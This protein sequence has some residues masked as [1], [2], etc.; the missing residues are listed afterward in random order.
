MDFHLDHLL[1][2][3]DVTVSSC[4]QQEGFIFLQLDFI[5]DG[6]LCPHCQTYTDNL[7]Q[8]RP[9]L[10]RDLSIFGQG[11]YLKVPRRQF[12]CSQCGKYPTEP[13][14]FVNKRSNYTKRYQEYIY[15]KVKELT[16]EQVSKNEQLSPEKV[17]NIFQKMTKLKKKDWGNPERLGLDEFSRQKGQGN[18]VTVVSNLDEGSLLEVINS[19]KSEEIIEALKQQPASIR[20]NIQ[21]VCVDMW[22]GFKKVIT[23]VFPNALVVI[24]RF[25]VIK[26][27]NKALNKLRLNL[28]LKG[29]KNRCLLLKNNQDLTE[30]EQRELRELLRISPCLSIAYELKEELRDIY[31][32]TTTVKKGLRSL[33]KWLISARV[34]FGKTADP[35]ESHLQDICHYFIQRT[36]NGT[37]E[38]LNNKIKLIL[39]QSYGFSNFDSMR[40]KLLACLF[41]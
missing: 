19:H 6:I 5:N 39:R 4:Q 37:M 12:I 28:D 24:D 32:E 16:I 33:K 1:N 26:L 31:E 35:L 2:L 38:G 25:H 29:L 15:E 34:I 8:T 41:K 13:L 23:E 27:V 3:P 14:D 40:E 20:E 21:E 10:V 30:E 7:H 17:Q 36:T 11:V 18:L 9:V 22:G